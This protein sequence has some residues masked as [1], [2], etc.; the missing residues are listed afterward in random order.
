[1]TQTRASAA[2][3]RRAPGRGARRTDLAAFLR[4]RR[5]RISPEDVGMPPGPRRRTPGLRREEVAQ[6]AGV[7][8]TWY[9]WLEQGRPINA[10]PQVLDA[11]ART[12]RLDPAEREHLYALAG[13]TRRPVPVDPA[14]GLPDDVPVI[15]DRLDPM[16]A[17]VVS[18]RSD[19]I[20][21]NSAYAA[22]IW[23]LP[24]VPP[25]ERNTMWLSFT[26]PPCCNPI[27]NFDEQAHEAVAIFRYRYSRHMGDPGWKDLVQ[28]LCAASPEF[29]RLWA[30]HDVAPPR[31]CDKVYRHPAV[32]EIALRS[33]G[34]DLTAAPGYR[35]I[36]YN[37]VGQR[38]ADRIA[39]LLAH[40][41]EAAAALP[42]HRH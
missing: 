3:E 9:T 40:P 22:V 2:G 12:L 7:G 30:T 42:D 17:A 39:H 21:W 15:L 32:G 8:V 38:D 4:S 6:L 18:E 41:R 23:C 29:A 11:V 24:R 37:P 13:V 35:M 27:V 14:E 34:L 1:M 20:A 10:S 25:C 31:P 26:W 28:R 19:V 5:E 36:V 33:T 16:P